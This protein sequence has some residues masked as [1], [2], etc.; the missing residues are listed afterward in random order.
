M[1]NIFQVKDQ[2]LIKDKFDLKGSLYKRYTT[3]NKVVN[4]H[5]KKELNLLE[6]KVKI[7]VS[8]EMK[9]RLMSQI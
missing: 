3:K 6:E 4:G 2:A 9:N 1:N 8:V 5:A 7:K